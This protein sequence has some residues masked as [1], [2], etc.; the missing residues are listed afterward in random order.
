MRKLSNIKAQGPQPVLPLID[1]GEVTTWQSLILFDN[2]LGAEKLLKS[3]EIEQLTKYYF[4]QSNISVVRTDHLEELQGCLRDEM[5]RADVGNRAMVYP[6]KEKF[7]DLALDT[8]GKEYSGPLV[9]TI[10]ERGKGENDLL[11]LTCNWGD[12]LFRNDYYIIGVI[13]DTEDLEKMIDCIR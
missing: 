2:V 13:A 3:I 9:M 11:I 4:G 10:I 6:F 12:G 5:Y 8:H 1:N 7:E